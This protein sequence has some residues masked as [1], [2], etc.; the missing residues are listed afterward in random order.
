MKLRFAELPYRTDALEPHYSE[1][2]LK[3]HYQKHHRAYFDKTVELIQG[4]DLEDQTLEQIIKAAA[5]DRKQTT[6]FNNA[7][8]V[9]N[10]DLFWRSVMPDGGGEP[11]AELSELIERDFGSYSELRESLKD[12]AVNQ[13]GSGWAWL[14]FDGS[15]LSA[16]STGNADNPLVHGKT[17]LLALDVWEHAYYVDYQNR[18][19]E[20][21]DAFL[22][23]LVNWRHAVEL[24]AGARRGSEPGMKR[25]AGGRSRS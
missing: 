19:A 23:N 2:M 22:D 17:A 1:E 11:E 14:V 20:Y 5:K 18:R 16:T 25:A 21:V 24:M 15:K 7:A 10:H 3:L 13:F 12:H 6:L 9:W 4:T 8:Q